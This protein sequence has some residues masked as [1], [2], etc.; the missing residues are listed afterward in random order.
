MLTA[1]GDLPDN[2]WYEGSVEDGVARRI[3]NFL[4]YRMTLKMRPGLPPFLR[5][6]NGHIPMTDETANWLVVITRE[7]LEGIAQPPDR[8]VERLHQYLDTF[9]AVATYKLE[10]GRAGAEETIWVQKED[11]AEYKAAI[12]GLRDRRPPS[13]I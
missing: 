10:H 12:S 6:E 7:A 2:N 8:S 13:E 1:I 4:R 11:V 9:A 5:D 3:I